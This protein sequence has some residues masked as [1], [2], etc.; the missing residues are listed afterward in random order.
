VVIRSGF[1][2]YQTENL[3]YLRKNLRHPRETEND[4]HS[5]KNLFDLLQWPVRRLL[6]QNRISG[7]IFASVFKRSTL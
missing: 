7:I 4:I 6:F 2:W 3:R 1:L 5:G